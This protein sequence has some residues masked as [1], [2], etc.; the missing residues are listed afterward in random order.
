MKKFMFLVMFVVTWHTWEDQ[1]ATGNYIYYLQD[2]HNYVDDSR[3]EVKETSKRNEFSTYAE[4]QR[5]AEETAKD[6]KNWDVKIYR[7]EE[8]K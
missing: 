8:V 2:E 1:K 3:C 4:A 5:F 6:R 7:M